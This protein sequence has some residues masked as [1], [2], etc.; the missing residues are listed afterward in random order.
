[1]ISRSNQL[2]RDAILAEA[3]H[4]GVP[5]AQESF[6]VEHGLAILRVRRGDRVL[7]GVHVRF[8]GSSRGLPD[9]ITV[10][11]SGHRA[12]RMWPRKRNGTFNIGAVVDHLLAL[13]RQETERA[14]PDLSFVSKHVAA[15]ISGLHVMHATAILVGAM[16]T[17]S[18]PQHLL[19]KVSDERR[20]AKI[21]AHV[22]GA[23][24]HD[25]DLRVLGDAIRVFFGRAT[26]LDDIDPLEPISPEILTLLKFGRAREGFVER[27]LVLL[28]TRRGD[29]ITIA[30]PA[31]EGVVEMPIKD[32]K[33]ALELAAAHGRPWVGMGSR[34]DR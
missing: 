17:G 33:A 6:K 2:L 25:S 15:G 12:S 22:Q 13:V 14:T 1:M 19:D 9:V 10:H 18:S 3:S 31:G 26:K 21:T 34:W 30:D 8:P 4:R 24:L 28:L 27:R 32:A 16:P 23:G 29:E 5:L 11:G 7:R 20:R